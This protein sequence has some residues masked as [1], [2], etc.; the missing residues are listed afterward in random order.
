MLLM[1]LVLLL[2]QELLVQV[3]IG[4]E[5][6][7]MPENA[8]KSIKSSKRIGSDPIDFLVFI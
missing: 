4:L 3:F 5:A 7:L 8:L 1:K 2:N 6:D